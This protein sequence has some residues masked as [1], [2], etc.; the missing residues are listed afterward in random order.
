MVVIDTPMHNFTVPAV[1]KVWIDYVVRRRTFRSS[2]QGKV[3]LLRDRPVYV[4]AACGGGFEAAAGG[5]TDFLTPYLRYA[6]AS[7]GLT[8]VEML[9]LD[10][11]RRGE[12]AVARADIQ[13][14]DWIASQLERQKR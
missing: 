11:L 4:I 10:S 12:A 2:P 14:A 13:A 7:V 5:Q 9:R 3:G 1:L 8:D 6:L